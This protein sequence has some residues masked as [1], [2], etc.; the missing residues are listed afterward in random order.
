[1]V[2][3]L[4]LIRVRTLPHRVMED[5]S[6]EAQLSSLAWATSFGP[7]HHAI[8]SGVL[9]PELADAHAALR[10]RHPHRPAPPTLAPLHGWAAGAVAQVRQGGG[11]VRE[12]GRG[13]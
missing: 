5:R 11:A 7:G 8:P 9:P 4:T 13:E 3:E 10:P 2:A 6:L 12:A 1:M